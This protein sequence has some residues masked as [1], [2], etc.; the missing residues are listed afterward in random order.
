MATAKQI[1]VGIHDQ[2]ERFTR[3]QAAH[4]RAYQRAAAELAENL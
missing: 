4:D 1:A 2:L 3:Y